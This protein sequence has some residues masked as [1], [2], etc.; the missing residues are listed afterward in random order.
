MDR[1][2]LIWVYLVKLYYFESYFRHVKNGVNVEQNI[3]K[4]IGQ[5]SDLKFHVCSLI[6]GITV[7]SVF[8]AN[9]FY[10]S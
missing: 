9:V 10:T 4:F 3:S 1:S 2:S 6:V 5:L 8:Q 7:F